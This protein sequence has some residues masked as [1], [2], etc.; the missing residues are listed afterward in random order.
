MFSGTLGKPALQ[1]PTMTCWMKVTRPSTLSESIGVKPQGTTHI[2][3]ILIIYSS[4][5]TKLPAWRGFVLNKHSILGTYPPPQLVD[6]YVNSCAEP[7]WLNIVLMLP[8]LSYSFPNWRLASGTE[9]RKMLLMMLTQKKQ[10]KML[11]LVGA[12]L[13]HFCPMSCIW[14]RA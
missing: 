12:H 3:L 5:P 4:D 10:C 13:R 7:I 1:R 2:S 9:P 8:N 11:I 6:N 14:L